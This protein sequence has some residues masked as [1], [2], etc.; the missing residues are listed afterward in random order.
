MTREYKRAEWND[1]FARLNTDLNN[2]QTDVQILNSDTGAQMLAEGLPFSGLTFD[3]SS[4][5]SYIEVSIGGI[6]GSHDSHTISNPV[7]VA[8]E[9][10]GQLGS[11]TLDI[12]DDKGVQPTPV[13]ASH[14]SAEMAA[15]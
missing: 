8:F 15:S 10:K 2:W 1:L 11:G 5:R 14:P 12:V 3:E 7:S 6:S 4:E 13:L 9:P